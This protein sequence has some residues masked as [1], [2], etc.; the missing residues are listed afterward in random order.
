MPTLFTMTTLL[1][2]MLFNIWFV[3]KGF[4][5]SHYN[6]EYVNMHHKK[7]NLIKPVNILYL[8]EICIP[9]SIIIQLEKLCLKLY[10]L[11]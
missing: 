7:E 4:V 3:I 8:L 5:I 2:P 1:N 10:G 11:F 6:I 9:K